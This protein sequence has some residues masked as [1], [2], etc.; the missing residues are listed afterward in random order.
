[1]VEGEAGV[2]GRGNIPQELCRDCGELS[3]HLVCRLCHLQ[4]ALVDS[5]LVSTL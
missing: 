2:R 5:H 4:S 1:M 3:S